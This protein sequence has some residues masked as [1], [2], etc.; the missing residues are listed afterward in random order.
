M[1]IR[2]Y[3]HYQNKEV[4]K[5]NLPF[6][7]KHFQY[8]LRKSEN[9]LSK[10]QNAFGDWLSVKR[11]DDT[12]VISQCF[13]GLSAK[14]I[15]KT[16]EILGDGKNAEVYDNYFK[17]IRRAFRENYLYKYGKIKGDSQTVYAFSLAVDFV[18]VSE[19]KSHFIASLEREDYKLTTG[20][21]GVKY[22][23][24]ALCE[25]GETDLAYKIIKQTEYPSWGYTVKH[26]AT[27]IWERWNGYTKEHG[28]ETPNMNSFN[29]Y[30]LGSCVEWLYT[31]VLGIKLFEDGKI[32]ISPSLSEE[33][34]FARGEYKS[35]NGV[36]S[37][38][39]EYKDG[40]YYISV[41]AKNVDFTYDFADRTI[42]SVEKSNGELKAVVK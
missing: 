40:K 41:D 14:L 12:K 37:V 29:H 17:K 36:I 11:S 6:A 42:I 34:S 33:L 22:V 32:C 20:F 8:Y 19:I 23:L 21:I 35:L 7:V 3:L 15:S 2:N 31:H 26:G 28:F 25:I 1:I 13:F 16:Y 24:P 9:Y 5:E 39:W 27:T 38:S 18:S 30:S 4:L 10:V